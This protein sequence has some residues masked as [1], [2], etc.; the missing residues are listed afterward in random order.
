M[1]RSIGV[2]HVIDYRETDYT[3]TGE[4]YDLILD[5]VARRS[6]LAYRRAL[7]P[8]GIFIMVGG[9]RSTIFQVVFLG[10]IISRMG[11]RKLGLNPWDKNPKEDYE[12]LAKLFE[13]GKVVPVIDRQVPLSG[14]PEALKDL[15]EG[16]VLGK[17][18]VSI[19]HDNAW[20]PFNY[21]GM[22]P[23]SPASIPTKRAGAKNVNASAYR[24]QKKLLLPIIL[25][26][27]SL[28]LPNKSPPS[29]NR[30]SGYS[31]A[32]YISF[33]VVSLWKKNREDESRSE[34]RVWWL[35]KETPY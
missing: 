33:E 35:E 17:V 5:T 18:V 22:P 32:W 2:D 31:R 28:H 21:I 16:Q 23:I 6:I 25:Q 13:A 3:K 20:W 10:S 27:W 9:S 12:F 11:S 24:Q 26:A 7:N 15:E 8:D 34:L 19:E 1:L 4:R 30:T 14:V 29:S